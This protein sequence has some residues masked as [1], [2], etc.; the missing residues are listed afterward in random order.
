VEEA[1]YLMVDRKR[2]EPRLGITFKSM[3]S[4]TSFLELG[5]TF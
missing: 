3:P 1:A 5:P 4:M 2:D